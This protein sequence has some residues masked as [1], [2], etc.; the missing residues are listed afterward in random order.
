MEPASEESPDKLSTG[1]LPELLLSSCVGDTTLKIWVSRDTSTLVLS[2]PL[3][4]GWNTIPSV[5]ECL[6]VS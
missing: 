5:S 3:T 4:T 6:F 2:G 1:D